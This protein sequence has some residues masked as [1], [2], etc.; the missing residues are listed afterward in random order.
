MAGLMIKSLSGI[1]ERK[2]WNAAIE[3][4]ETQG[5]ETLSAGLLVWH[6]SRFASKDATSAAQKI[7]QS[8]TDSSP[9]TIA[10]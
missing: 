10:R 6:G 4:N 9:G 5:G 1:C 2:V 7:P 8:R 3:R